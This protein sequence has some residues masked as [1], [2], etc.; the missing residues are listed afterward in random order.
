MSLCLIDLKARKL[1]FAGANNPLVFVR[2]GKAI[3][4]KAD[5]MPIG[6]YSEAKGAFTNQEFDLL[7]GD[8]F[9][10]F[11]DGFQDQ[12]GGPK[13]KKFMRK[14]M[15]E[16]FVRLQDQ[17]FKEQKEKLREAFEA[18]RGEEHQVDDVIVIGFKI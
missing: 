7:M 12:F 13:G 18:W 1:Q 9:Y 2:D 11:S 3:E 14:Q 15:K 8:A 10:I 17:P 4:S 6:I 5:R 16:I